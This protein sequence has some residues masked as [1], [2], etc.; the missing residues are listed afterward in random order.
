MNNLKK[1]IIM[2]RTALLFITSAL[3]IGLTTPCSRH[4]QKK[5][6]DIERAALSLIQEFQKNYKTISDPEIPFNEKNCNGGIVEVALEDFAENANIIVTDTHGASTSNVRKFLHRAALLVG[7]AKQIEITSFDCIVLSD[8]T[9]APEAG[10]GMYTYRQ[11]TI[12]HY[13]AATHSFQQLKGTDRYSIPLYFSF[14]MIKVQYRLYM[15][16]IT[17]KTKP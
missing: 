4:I 15:G 5:T 13:D 6:S 16:D 12:L 7:R 2:T 3:F 1:N 10:E 9:P 8:L 14:P 17:I 11:K